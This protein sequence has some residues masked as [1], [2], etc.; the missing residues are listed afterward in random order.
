MEDN[1][2]SEEHVHLVLSEVFTAVTMGCNGEQSGG[3]SLTL[4]SAG[5]STVNLG[6]ICYEEA[7][8]SP[9]YR[10]L[11]P[12]TANS[13]RFAA[14]QSTEVNCMMHLSHFQQFVAYFPYF[15][16]CRGTMLQA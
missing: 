11:Q 8:C 13:S 1:D 14:Q 16:R 10:A 3:A 2:V 5:S 12:K 15:A 4:V 9:N 7:T 6:A